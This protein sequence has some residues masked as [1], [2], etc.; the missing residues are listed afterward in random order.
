MT[1]DTLTD[2]A[3]M[4]EL[5]REIKGLRADL[6]SER[7]PADQSAERFCEELLQSYGE[8]SFFSADL[9]EWS[10]ELKLVRA[11]L[12]QAMQHLCRLDCAPSALQLGKALRRLASAPPAGFAVSWQDVR[13]TKRWLV[14]RRWG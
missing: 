4:L 14:K 12:R 3:L 11:P 13:G 1:S 5:L 9:L 6:R 2:R 10:E 8:E 7:T